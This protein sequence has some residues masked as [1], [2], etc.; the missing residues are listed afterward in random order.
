MLSDS[1]HFRVGLLLALLILFASPATLAGE[2]AKDVSRTTPTAVS[3]GD[4]PQPRPSF[5]LAVRPFFTL[6]GLGI[7]AGANFGRVD[8]EAD[9][10]FML[11]NFNAGFQAGYR[12]PVATIHRS[13][14]RYTTF[15]LPISVGF[16]YF[17]HRE[18]EYRQVTGVPRNIWSINPTVEA[19]VRYRFGRR[20]GLDLGVEAG[21]AL[22][23]SR[24]A[25]IALPITIPDGE[26]SLFVPTAN[27]K[28]GFVF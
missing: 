24:K 7:S 18:S 11:L 2:S 25:R 26:N 23:F 22:P 5:A 28:A 13:G 15:D 1:R 10:G 14:N 12:I 6:A 21:A 16:R 27:L 8:F 3:N 9:A 20:F 4:I 19:A 17:D